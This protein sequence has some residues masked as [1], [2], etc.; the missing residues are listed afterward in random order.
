MISDL[1]RDIHMFQHAGQLEEMASSPTPVSKRTLTY[2]C[3]HVCVC[4][5]RFS[6]QSSH[7]AQTTPTISPDFWG[8]S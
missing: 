8:T 3:M 6:L 2:M 7:I 4:T 1:A 5:M